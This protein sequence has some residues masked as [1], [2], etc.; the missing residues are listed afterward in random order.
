[1]RYCVTCKETFDF[2]PR[3]QKHIRHFEKAF[4]I[5]FIESLK[6]LIAMPEIHD[7]LTSSSQFNPTILTDLTS[8]HFCQDHPHF[9]DPKSIKVILYYDDIG[10]TNPLGTRD[11]SVCMFYWSLA[12]LPRYVRSQDRCMMLLA[13]V[14]KKYAKKHGF[15]GVLSDFFDSI[16]QLQSSR[17]GLRRIS[18]P[19]ICK[20]RQMEQYLKQCDQISKA[21]GRR[22]A[23]LQKNFGIISES[24]FTAIN[25]FDVFK[26]TTIDVMHVLLEGIYTQ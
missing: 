26:Q 2:S 12:N 14:E 19:N 23:I 20:I 3:K 11:R 15:K 5:P 13:S 6:E 8:G 22:K 1:M 10:I 18:R 25:G 7:C 21:D 9:R 24:P 16:K 17:D 4:C